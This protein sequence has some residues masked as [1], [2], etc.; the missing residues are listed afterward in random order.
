MKQVLQ[1]ELIPAGLQPFCHCSHRISLV[2]LLNL[3]IWLPEYIQKHAEVEGEGECESAQV[4]L[5]G[6][7]LVSCLTCTGGCYS[8]KKAHPPQDI[9]LYT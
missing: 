9:C 4:Y 7:Q 6:H 5:R 3:C 8:P 2:R 1:M